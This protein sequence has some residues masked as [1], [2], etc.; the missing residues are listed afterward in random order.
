M[1]TAAAT[2]RASVGPPPSPA[3]TELSTANKKTSPTKKHKVK[4]FLKKYAKMFRST[5]GL[6]ILLLIYSFSGAAV[7]EAIESPNENERKGMINKM[8]DDLIGTLY[9][10]SR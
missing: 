7:F 6:F 2:G 8:R 3:P 5:I 1:L 9:N 10:A 4:R